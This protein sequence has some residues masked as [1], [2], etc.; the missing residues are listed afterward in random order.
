M[1]ISQGLDGV[2]LDAAIQRAFGR[3]SR[4]QA[5]QAIVAGAVRLNGK[6][7]KILARTVKQ[8]D[9]LAIDEGSAPPKSPP[10]DR[11]LLPT[12]LFED[13]HLLVVDKPARLL[14]ERVPGENGVAIQDVVRERYGATWL[15]HRL[16]AGTSGVMMLARDEQSALVLSE[17]FRRGQVEKAYLLLCAGDPGAGEYEGALGRDPSHGRRFCV[18]PD[19]K[20][21]RTRYRTLAIKDGV[22][23][24]SARPETGRTHQIRVH[25]ASAGHPLLGDRLYGGIA[26]TAGARPRLIGRP[27]LHAFALAFAHP[28]SGAGLRFVAAPP[29]DF[30]ELSQALQLTT[31]FDATDPLW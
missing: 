17:A 6:I 27:M 29:A 18:R 14:S 13:R 3:H 5:R 9:K 10:S 24:A 26:K 31:D 21:A 4:K 22:A 1:E 16:D 11:F 30:R 20:R 2:R 19:G 15:V 7:V 25:F 28:K 23:L 12:V 8:G